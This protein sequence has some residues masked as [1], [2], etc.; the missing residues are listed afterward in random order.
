MNIEQLIKDMPK[1]RLLLPEEGCGYSKVAHR[2]IVGGSPAQ[3]GAWP[4]MALLGGLKL[5]VRKLLL[6]L[7]NNK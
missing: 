1:G 2:R 3:N 6:E 7:Y 4:W 5:I